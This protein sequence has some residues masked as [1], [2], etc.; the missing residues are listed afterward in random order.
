MRLPGWR[1]L[2][3]CSFL[4]MSSA[5]GAEPEPHGVASTG[6]PLTLSDAIGEALKHRPELAAFAFELREN[7]AMASLA[8]QKPL[9]ELE[10]GLEDA[11]G[12]G[13]YKGLRAAQ[14]TFQLSQII[15]LGDKRAGRL[16]VVDAERK[17]ITTERAI[18]QLDVVAEVAR[19]FV[20]V[21][22]EQ[23]RHAM[24]QEAL[25]LARKTQDHVRERVAAARVPV[26]EGA[27]AA[28]AVIDAQVWL[29]DTDHE[30]EI[31][32][33]HLAAAMGEREARFGEAQG[34]LSVLDPV[35]P[36][37][38]L[39]E[40]LEE[41]PALLQFADEK[42]LREAELRLAQ[43]Q[44]RA[45][46]RASIGLR[47]LEQS[48][49][50]GLMAGISIPLFQEKKV[51]PQIDASHA[52][53]E[54]VQSDREA[55][56]LRLQSEIYSHYLQLG[57]SKELAATLQK[58]LIPQLE[59]SLSLTADAYERGRYGYQELLTAQRELLAGRGRLLE[60]FADYQLLRIE[61]ERLSADSL[62]A[63]G[64]NP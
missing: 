15:E 19:R 41:S 6:A 36:L 25:A 12:T 55:A 33:R 42:R 44:Q 59:T 48:N 53:L 63:I 32:R 52:R 58:D 35:A 8:G 5:R 45:S 56:Y 29:D 21:V 30:L 46:M 13:S 27:R 4:I 60:T 39:L 47:R 14:A 16:A 11:L 34:S 61:I 49:D 62:D 3:A 31:A 23:E 7:S 10:F 9:P 40:R 1:A 24:A 64:A 22:R 57:H 54:R 37:E 50:F 38:A 2:L 17:S 20:E 28:V 26:A 51:Q 43:L 18:R